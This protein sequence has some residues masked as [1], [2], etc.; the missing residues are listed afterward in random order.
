MTL[1]SSVVTCFV[2][3]KNHE[4]A[5]SVLKKYD[6]GYLKQEILSPSPKSVLVVDVPGEVLLVENEICIIRV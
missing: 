4:T 2:V 5:C 6:K 1:R 3:L